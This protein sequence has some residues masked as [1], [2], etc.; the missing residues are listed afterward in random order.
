MAS[1]NL[2]S[3]GQSIKSS[4]QGVIN[5]PAPSSS[6]PTYAQWALFSVQAPLANAFQD[7]GS[8]ESI[9]KVQSTGDG[10]L[11]DLIEDFSE[12]RIQFAF[13]KV[14][15]PNSG[16]PKYALIAW[17][18]GGVPERTKGYFTTHTAAVSKILHGYHVQITARSDS[19]LEPESIVKKIADA[20]GAKYSAGA[21]STASPAPPPVA[22]KPVFNP[23]ASSASNPLVAARNRRGGNVDED[24]WGEDAPQVSRTQLEKVDSAYKPTKVN[25][26]ELTSQ[27]QEP[28]RFSASSKQQDDG[29][30]VRGGYQP[31]G[32]VDIAAIRA[33]AKN[34]VDDRPTTVKG[35]YEPIGKVDIAAI[36]AKAQQKPSEPEP[37]ARPAAA[38]DEQDNQPKSLAERS[39]AFSQSSQPERLTSLPKPKVA[40]KFGG[41]AS[42]G[43]TKAP[44]P[45]GLGLLSPTTATP[46]AAPVGAASRTFA[47]Q[48]GKTPAQ[49][50]AEKKAREGGGAPAAAPIAA[51]NSGAAAAPLGVQK[52]GEWK[53][54]YS[55]K[56]WGAVQTGEYGRGIA[57]KISQEN[58]GEPE[59]PKDRSPKSLAERSAAFS[60]SS[61]P[62]RLTSLPKPKVANKFGGAASFGGTK[63]P[64]PGGLGLLGPTAATPAAAP[65]GA[66]SRTFADQGGKTPA[67]LWAEK[68][69]REGG[70]APA[71]APIAAQISGA[72]AAPLGVQKS[73]EWKSGYSGKSWGA[74]QTGE[75]GRGIA[76]KISQEN[77]GE[78]EQPKDRSVEQPES[79]AGGV[80]ALKD[81]FKDTTPIG[82]GAP[83]PPVPSFSREEPEEEEPREA[84]PPPPPPSDSRPTGGF[85][86]PGLPSRPPPPT[87]EE[88]DD[89]P[90]APP[91]PAERPAEPQQSYDEPEHS[92]VGEY[93]R[94]IAGKI[95]Q[96]NTG[97]P[98]QPKDRSVEQP[99]SPAGG[100]GALK[101]RFKDTAPIGFGAPP[102]PVPSFSR[103]EPEEEEPREASPP[104]P[105]PSDSRPTG[106]FALPGLP[107]RPPPPTDEEEDDEPP[108]PPRPAERPAE[109]QQSY[110]EPEHSPVRVAVPV[111]RGPEPEIEP[112]EAH[113][114]RP[115]PTQEFER[116]LPREQ[117]LPEEAP[118]V[119]RGA[120]AAVAQQEL[121]EANIP[122]AQTPAGAQAGGQRALIQYDYEKAEDNEIELREGQYVT[123][124][125]MVDE[126][127]WMGTNS[128]GESGLFPSNYVEL[129]EDE[130]EQ[131]AVAAPAPAARSLPPPAPAQAEPER[132]PQAAGRTATALFDYEAA[133]DNE[134]GFR[135]NDKITDIEFPD[136]DWWF[137]HLRGKQGLF[138]ANYVELD[139]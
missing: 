53:S 12:G 79:P 75:Y 20:S 128:K 99:E 106:G 18:G 80:G 34:K 134:L 52:S 114:P 78:P 104:P 101:D 122:A 48:G 85:A 113:A 112:A 23:T 136:E 118:N 116:E 11:A 138:P 8:K 62:E 36:R 32:K 102:P 3:N 45:G 28:S 14:K 38:D 2:S 131:A 56:S 111:A 21:S 61:Q 121:S 7:S 86:L 68:K 83:P 129:V 43:G 97:E 133:E 124:I 70:R 123:N 65:V 74:V 137:G 42:F 4:Y 64:T 107:S 35:A 73:G 24:G 6:S 31:I 115:I 17:C 26:A 47:D 92:P 49:L 93:G 15:D 1:L 95:S 30:V 90:P 57:G 59:Q 110:D 51:Q 41:A 16:L 72:A 88:E 108:A 91:R 96:E 13:V 54:G 125:E 109:P 98:E 105:P 126:D 119:G 100:V 44:T 132:Q 71:A 9:L 37:A 130:P 46:A 81:R 120:A 25:M 84:S 27:R 55:G 77:T 19:D 103:D 10:E 63:A 29:D 135:E 76:G 94:G 67:Q 117:D 127:W 89:E 39:A 87:D 22:S 5:G 60:Q 66:A 139:Q 40:N 33:A 69:A 50:W 58:T 82:F